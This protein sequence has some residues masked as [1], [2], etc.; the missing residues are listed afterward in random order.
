M[1]KGATFWFWLKAQILTTPDVGLGEKSQGNINGFRM[2][3]PRKEGGGD[4]PGLQR[5]TIQCWAC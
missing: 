2:N 3:S 5:K 1:R 4:R